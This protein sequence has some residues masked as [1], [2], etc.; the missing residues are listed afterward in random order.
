MY[1]ALQDR[2]I[3]V[4][5][6]IAIRMEYYQEL[7]HA[8]R[9]LNHPGDALVLQTDFLLMVERVD[10]CIEYFQDHVRRMACCVSSS[11]KLM[12]SGAAPILRSR[13]L[14]PQIPTMYDPCD[15]SD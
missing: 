11:P 5:D 8:T 4:T 2:L 15:D 10:V 6:A 3:E 12:S 13:C 1:L 7:D 9:M 14:P